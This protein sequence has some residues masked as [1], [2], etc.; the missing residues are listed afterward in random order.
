MN[1]YIEKYRII[2]IETTNDKND[3][4]VKAMNKLP[5]YRAELDKLSTVIIPA[6]SNKFSISLYGMDGYIKYRSEKFT[7]WK[8]FIQI[9]NSMQMQRYIIDFIKLDKNIGYNNTE[10]ANYTLNLLKNEPIKIKFLI[11][12][13]L[14]NEAK[15]SNNKTSGMRDAIRIYKNWLDD[16]NSS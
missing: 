9:I 1:K 13:T 7:S 4:Y 3:D 11:I 8:V 12:N 16:Y 5:K 6:Y 10:M 15:Y 14:Y 2:L